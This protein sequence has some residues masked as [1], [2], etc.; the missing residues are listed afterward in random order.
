MITTTACNIRLIIEMIIMSHMGIPYHGEYH[1]PHHS[2]DQC[3]VCMCR[4]LF[5][6][7]L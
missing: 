7:V 6:S 3:W 4:A 5:L 2:V 1:P